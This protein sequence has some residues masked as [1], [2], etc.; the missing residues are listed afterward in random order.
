VKDLKTPQSGFAQGLDIES[1]M[2]HLLDILMK[3]A[4]SL[5]V[6]ALRYELFNNHF[7]F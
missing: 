5:R 1:L 7:A 3:Y 2:D 4:W 6:N